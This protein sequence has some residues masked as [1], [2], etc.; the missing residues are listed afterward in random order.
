MTHDEIRESIPGYALHALAPEDARDVEA[1]LATCAECQRELGVFEDAAASL[2]IG[3]A[4]EEP[5]AA[6]R[7]RVLDAV[8]SR[9][10]TGALGVGWTAAL[11]AAAALIVVL[12][13]V[14]L[15]LEQRLGALTARVDSETQ[16]LALLADPASRLVT[17]SGSAGGR[18]RFVF[19]PATGRGALVAT[20]LRNPGS[21]LVY[22]LWLVAGA[23]PHSAGVFRPSSGTPV[24]VAVGADFPRYQ[25][26]AISVERGPNGAA[27]PSAAPVLVGKLGGG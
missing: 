22:Q 26:V 4:P 6:L 17:L 13:G 8:R 5:P 20:G 3:F 1:H 18:V 16:A 25:A 21:D 7:R 10:R 15:S 24:I 19:D 11:A 23:A 14:A 27:R 9:R 12:A 2:A